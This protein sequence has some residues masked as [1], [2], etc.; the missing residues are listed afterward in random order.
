MASDHRSSPSPVTQLENLSRKA[1]EYDLFEAIRLLDS[2]FRS[3]P[4]TGHAERPVFEMF[5]ISQVASQRFAPTAIAKFEKRA[6]R[7]Y[8]DLSNHV[9]GVFGPNGALPLHLTDFAEQRIRHHRDETFA[10]FVDLFHHRMASF[11]Y[12]A[13]ADA[14]PTVQMDRPES[15]RFFDYVASLAGIGTPGL[16]NRDAMPDS[17]KL[18]FS[19]FL[20]NSA[21]SASNLESMLQSFF[22]AEAQILQFVGKWVSL[23]DDCEWWLGKTPESGTLGRN[24]TLGS[25]VL[26]YQQHFRVMLGPLD[27]AA[28]RKLLPN[29]SSL[30]R[31]KA[32]LD[33]F[34]GFEL[35]WDV[36][37]CLRKEEVP[38]LQLGHGGNLG[39]T[40]WFPSR[41]RKRDADDL[42]ID[43]SKR[44]TVGAF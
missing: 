23:P 6:G 34:V 9:F 24:V 7:E 17:A 43:P 36:Q 29:G 5:R 13:W 21:K 10:R 19:G 15:N 32:M 44:N 11:F 8:W 27:L 16:Q 35:T 2:L 4:R 18:H 3:S 39:W 40:T 28:F 31:L 30:K 14:Q 33:N 20:G 37:L 12:R 42:V 41:D 22:G 25:K 38:P 26:C 1:N